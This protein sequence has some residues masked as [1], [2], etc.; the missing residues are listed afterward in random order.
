[1]PELRWALI[2]LG[3]A[4]F[5]GL[6][7]FEWRR[8]GRSAPRAAAP[9]AP[10]RGE[11]PRRIEPGLDAV[12]EVRGAARESGLEVPVIHPMDPM[13]GRPAPP[14]AEPVP[15]AA[16][17]AVD[18]PA[19]ARGAGGE[20]VLAREAQAVPEAPAIV[21]PAPAPAP[22]PSSQAIRW[23][24][25]K[26][27]RALSLRLVGREGAPLAGRALRLA[28]EAAGFV[29]GPQDIYHRVDVGGGV[30][31][32]AASMVQPGT[33]EPALMDGQQY[34]GV[35]LFSVLPGP[36]PPAGMLDGLVEA[37]RELS[38][39]L[40]GVVQDGKGAEFDAAAREAMRQSLGAPS[41]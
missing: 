32:S 25:A 37:A 20:P 18:V 26:V 11:R 8:K 40:D 31:V 3:L 17:A 28:L 23:P 15:V 14:L 12:P 6:V 19:A 4:F 39:R 7:V 38:R 13:P 16:E 30:L 29:P 27:E 24:P 35:A 33:L 9:E 22:A 34:R 21:P 2:G 1:M 36:V 10:A 5:A 41:P